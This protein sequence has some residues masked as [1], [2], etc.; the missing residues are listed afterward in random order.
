MDFI[1]KL[2]EE[3]QVIKSAPF[4]FVIFLAVGFTAAFLSSNWYYSKQIADRDSQLKTKD[5]ELDEKDA[6]IKRYRV[7]LGIVKADKQALLDLTNDE[8]RA[9]ARSLA[10]IIRGICFDYKD[11]MT[12]ESKN[13]DSQKIPQARRRTLI[14]GISSQFAKRFEMDAKADYLN[15]DSQLRARLGPEGMG[16]IVMVPFPFSISALPLP[17]YC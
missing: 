15:V 11:A 6:T 12:R 13:W 10:G 7:E 17:R 3:G 14:A 9:K 2:R 8:L 1:Q 16:G 5:V 4:S